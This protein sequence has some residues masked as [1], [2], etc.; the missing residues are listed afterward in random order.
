MADFLRQTHTLKAKFV[1]TGIAHA[2]TGLPKIRDFDKRE[3]TD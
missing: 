3:R 1:N 2:Q